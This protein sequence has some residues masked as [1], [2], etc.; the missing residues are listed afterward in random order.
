MRVF[1]LNNRADV[2]KTQKF[3][4]EHGYH[5]DWDDNYIVASEGEDDKVK[6]ILDSAKVDY[7]E[8]DV[9][10]DEALL[11]ISAQLDASADS[12]FPCAVITLVSGKR[13]KVIYTFDGT[14]WF[15]AVYACDDSHIYYLR[16]TD[17]CTFDDLYLITDY[18]NEILDMENAQ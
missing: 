14:E 9:V 3:F 7:A 13:I 10:A 17:S 8:K 5:Y 18:I 12:I 11:E 6:R 15:F 16:Y 1:E 2:S 4:W